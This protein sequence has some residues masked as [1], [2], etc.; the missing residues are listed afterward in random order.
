[1]K[2]ERGRESYFLLSGG[3]SS[4]GI[5]FISRNQFKITKSTANKIFDPLEGIFVLLGRKGVDYAALP[6][7]RRM[8]AR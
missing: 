5:N 6:R 7:E 1:V 3:T 8:T 2:W 4:V